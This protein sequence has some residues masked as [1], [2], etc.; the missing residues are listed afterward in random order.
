MQAARAK[1]ANEIARLLGHADV[2]AA[3][4]S[5]PDAE[6]E[7]TVGQ[8]IQHLSGTDAGRRL[9]EDS[10]VPALG[11]LDAN[12]LWKKVL[13]HANMAKSVGLDVVTKLARLG[14]EI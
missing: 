8:A 14:I 2:G 9:V 3:L 11:D 12:P 7:R 4:A 10:L 5:L 1:H 6:V 13:T